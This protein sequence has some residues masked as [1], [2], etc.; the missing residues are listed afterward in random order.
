M[1]ELTTHRVFGKGGGQD[2]S[3]VVVIDEPDQG[4]A[5]H[6]YAVMAV[7]DNIDRSICNISFQNG[8]IQEFGVNGVQQEHLLAIIQDR[9]ECFQSGAFANQYNSEALE[10]VKLALAALRRRTAD[11]IARQVE[12]YNKA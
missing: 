12:G 5:C 2:T 7:G 3:T 8:P 9:L 11:R 6:E 4:G 1:R 10:Y